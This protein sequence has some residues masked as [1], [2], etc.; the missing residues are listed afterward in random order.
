V[1][2]LTPEELA[3]RQLKAKMKEEYLA[4]LSHEGKQLFNF[5]FSCKCKCFY[6]NNVK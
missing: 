3:K 6:M 1:V 5:S 2:E 4:A